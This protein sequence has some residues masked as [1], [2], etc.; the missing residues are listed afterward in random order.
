MLSRGV[1]ILLMVINDGTNAE[2]M[3]KV[4]VCFEGRHFK[5][6]LGH[7]KKEFSSSY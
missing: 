4:N 3:H 5:T 6:L 2:L 7:F 1:E